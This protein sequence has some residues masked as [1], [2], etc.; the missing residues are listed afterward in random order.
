MIFSNLPGEYLLVTWTRNMKELRDLGNRIE[1]E[2]GFDSVWPNI[3]YTGE[4]YPT[5][6]EKMIDELGS[7]SSLKV[8]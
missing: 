7:V 5:W 8:S 3:L 1:G 6:R 2:E 4:I